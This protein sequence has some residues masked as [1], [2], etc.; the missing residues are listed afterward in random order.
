LGGLSK[1]LFQIKNITE[2]KS[3]NRLLVDSGNLL[4]KR[5][6]VAK[7]TNQA[8][9]TAAAILEVYSDIDY[10]AVAVGPH[11]LAGGLSLLQESKASGFPW[12]SANIVDEN[13]QL[14]FES[15][16]TTEIQ[17]QSIVITAL[18]NAPERTVPGIQMQSWKKVLPPLLKEIISKNPHGFIILLSSLNDEA[19]R[20][21]AT[22]FPEISLLITADTRRGNISPVF[23]NNS[24]LTQTDRQGKYQGLL[25]ISFG[26]TRTWGKDSQKKLADLQNKL[27]SLNWQL[28]R[29][30]KKAKDSSA[31]GKYAATITRLENEKEVL[32]TKITEM[33]QQVVE[34]QKAGTAKDQFT[35][36]FLPLKKNMPNDP[37]TEERLKKLNSDIRALNKKKKVTKA[38][39]GQTVA[40]QLPQALIGSSTCSSCH[41]LQGDYWK[42]TRHATAYDTLLNKQKNFDLEC[43]PCHMTIDVPGGK[44][45][46]LVVETLLSYPEELQ[47]VGCETCHGNGKKHLQN[48]ERFKLVRTPGINICLTCHTDEHDDNFQYQLKLSKIACPAG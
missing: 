44:F 6:T 40:I 42:T 38:T 25:E 24:L 45:G 19:N 22:K 20:L 37:L 34:E 5:K 23:V 8:R 43:L 17:G 12:L 30:L 18:S 27:G 31:A 46:S 26:K 1:K 21:I 11:D 10:D 9:L 7:G 4:F 3:E 14:L 29:L 28:R 33:K 36:R 47:S 35:Y 41:E 2:N 16:I 48:P 13:E 39:T 32:T 15:V